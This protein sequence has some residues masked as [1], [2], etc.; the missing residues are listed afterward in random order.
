MSNFF[1]SKPIW[2]NGGI[3]LIK[4]GAFP[5]YHGTGMFETEKMQESIKRDE[6]NSYLF[7]PY[8]GKGA[9]FVAGILLLPARCKF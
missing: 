5:I 6:C 7:L 3:G 8:S 2:Q 1:S 4:T 9:E